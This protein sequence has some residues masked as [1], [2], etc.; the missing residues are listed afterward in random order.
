MLLFKIFSTLRFT[1]PCDLCILIFQAV[2]A[3]FE[4]ETCYYGIMFDGLKSGQIY[5]SS[6]KFTDLPKPLIGV[7]YLFSFSSRSLKMREKYISFAQFVYFLRK[8]CLLFNF[9][10]QKLKSKHISLKKYANLAKKNL[11]LIFIIQK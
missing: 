2:I 11:T 3:N 10:S 5:L 6:L 7:K 1:T 4:A 8:V 9:I